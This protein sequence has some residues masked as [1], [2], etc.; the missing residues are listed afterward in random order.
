MSKTKYVRGP[1]KK[2]RDFKIEEKEKLGMLP[3]RNCHVTRSRT[4]QAVAK[5]KL[6]CLPRETTENTQ[7]DFTL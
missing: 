4:A 2:K 3:R 1:Y 7:I 6:S 5:P